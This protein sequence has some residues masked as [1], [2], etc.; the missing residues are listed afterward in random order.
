MHSQNHI[1]LK[2]CFGMRRTF[3]KVQSSLY[4]RNILKTVFCVQFLV[5]HS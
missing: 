5:T 3:L 2:V 1:E 4:Y